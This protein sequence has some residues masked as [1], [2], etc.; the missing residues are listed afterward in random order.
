[1]AEYV[2]QLTK[3][4][5]LTISAAVADKLI[6]QGDGDAALLYLLLL[7]HHGRIGS[8]ELSKALRFSAPRLEAA[9]KTLAELGLLGE[10]QVE[11]TPAEEKPTYSQLEIAERLEGDETFRLLRT[12]V[13]KLLGR[14]MTTVDCT[15][16]LGLYDHLSLP[17]DV[18]YQLV[19]HCV[20]R[21]E[22]AYGAGRRPTL[23]QIEK[24]G[25]LWQRRGIDSIPRANAY[26]KTYHQRQGLL[27]AYM[28]ALQ[29]GERNPVPS[30]EKYLTEWMD[31]GFPPEVVALAYDRT[32]LRC[33]ELK[34]SYL[35]G[36]LKKWNEKGL[37]TVEAI[38]QGENKPAAKQNLPTAEE[39]DIQK[40]VQKMHRKR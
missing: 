18:I 16:L 15:I 34:W 23:R 26:L 19:C 27:P 24:E 37:R 38:E 25:Y 3:Q 12:E 7:R 30:E 35:G 32:M 11:L 40:Y 1:M 6:R 4:E 29:L 13:E 5:Q 8:A 21:S 17:A 39:N 9:E 20:E 33:H 22:R 10:K 2:L 31:M 14:R 28:R 36:I